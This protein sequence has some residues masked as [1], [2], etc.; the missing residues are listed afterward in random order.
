MREQAVSR[1]AHCAGAHQGDYSPR[2]LAEHL[3]GWKSGCLVVGCC[4]FALPFL[5]HLVQA[6]FTAGVVLPHALS[7]CRYYHRSLNPKKLIAI[8]FSH[9]NKK[10]TMSA[11]IKLYAL[12]DKVALAVLHESAML[13]PPFSF[14]EHSFLILSSPV[15]AC[16]SWSAF[17]G[18]SR[19]AGRHASAQ[20]VPQGA[21]ELDFT[22]VMAGFHSFSLSSLAG[23]SLDCGV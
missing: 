4:F 2:Q 14:F 18:A 8:G 17:A 12:P 19:R 15:S 5:S 7:S 1:Q 10:L 6:V 3:A 9:Q 20:C 22:T 16:H 13:F 23:L 11:T 21:I